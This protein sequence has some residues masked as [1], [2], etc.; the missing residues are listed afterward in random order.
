MRTKWISIREASEW[1]ELSRWQTKRRLQAID[2]SRSG[3]LLRW[4][5]KPGGKLEVNVAML[6]TIL[7]ANEGERERELAE[8]HERVDI[9]DN[10]T[11]A[12]RRFARKNRKAIEAL[13]ISQAALNTSIA[14][15]LSK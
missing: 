11:Y 14:Q 7:T 13:Q 8:I 9:I 12:I 2:Q 3:K 6:K 4:A 15:L 5:G 1:M 10:R